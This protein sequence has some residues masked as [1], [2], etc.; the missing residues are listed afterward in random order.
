MT[1]NCFRSNIVTQS[2]HDFGTLKYSSPEREIKR[3]K[4]PSHFPGL[5]LKLWYSLVDNEDMSEQRYNAIRAEIAETNRMIAEAM[6]EAMIAVAEVSDNFPL[7]S[8][9]PRATLRR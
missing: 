6:A 7:E 9:Q 3:K 1:R 4:F 5:A 2:R 8:F